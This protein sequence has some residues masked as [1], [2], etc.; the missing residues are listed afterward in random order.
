MAK[1]PELGEKQLGLYHDSMPLLS[2]N[3]GE[4]AGFPEGK[5]GLWGISISP[6]AGWLV[7]K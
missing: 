4:T 6:E 3:T 5:R 2:H 1:I 7:E